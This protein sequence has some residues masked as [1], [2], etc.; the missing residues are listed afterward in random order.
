MASSAIRFSEVTTAVDPVV[1]SASSSSVPCPGCRGTDWREIIGRDDAYQLFE[2]VTCGCCRIPPTVAAPELYDQY[3]SEDAAERLAGPFNALWRWKRRSRA[4]LILRGLPS[5]AAVCDVGCERGELLNL[6]KAGGCAV[7]GT[8]M[9]VAAAKFAARR[10]GIDVFVGELPDAPFAGHAF[11]AMLMLNIL[12]HLPDP[13]RYVAQASTMVRPGGVF[14]VELPN[15][16]SFTARFALKNW[17]H[18]DP[19]HHLWSLNKAGMLRMIERHGF[20]IDRIY[21]QNWE[22]NPIGCLQSWLNFLPGPKN[23]VFSVVRRGFSRQTAPLIRELI[24]VV[25]GAALLP[26]ATAVAWVEGLCENGQVLLIR[27]RRAAPGC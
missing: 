19:E 15:V 8:Q 7:V 1:T 4:R 26:L 18:H 13:E 11:D 27:A 9:S 22:F 25:L 10:F 16:G 24:H 2:C 14:W 21:S 23:V 6:L 17:F 12:E 3:Y 20:V 5:G